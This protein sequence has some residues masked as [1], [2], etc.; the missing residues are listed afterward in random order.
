MEKGLR[1]ARG[2]G[3]VDADHYGIEEVKERMLE[4]IAVLQ[5]KKT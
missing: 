1:Q 4:F 5:L 3:G 2:G